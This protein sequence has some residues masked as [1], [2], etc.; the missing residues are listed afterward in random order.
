MKL[1]VVLVTFNRLECLK[2]SLDKYAKQTVLP[3]YLVVVNNASTDGTKEYLDRWYS[4]KESSF[5]KILLHSD[6]N[7]GGSGGFYLGMECAMNLDCD[8]VFLA[9]DDA[10]AE[11]NMVERLQAFE[12]EY[13][14]REELVAMCTA[15]KNKGKYDC[16]QRLSWKQGFLKING[17]ASNIAD[18]QKESFEIDALTFVGAVIRRD[19]IEKIGLPSKEYFI[20]F[21]DT[22]YSMRLRKQGKIICIPQSIMHHDT[23]DIVNITWKNYYSLRNQ[24]ITI[25]KHYPKRYYYYLLLTEYVKKCSILA[26]IL[27]KRSKA[28]RIMYKRAIK[29]AIHNE[30]GIDVVYKPG[31]NIEKIAGK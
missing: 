23:E 8:Y 7:L 15:I 10:Y 9:D 30:L 29:A 27:K 12:N 21:D 16:S 20:H 3:S 11:P 17:K 4:N 28:Q 1:A 6:K 2:I 31:I 25:C 5:E 14:C 18:Y 26:S 24:L 22:E 19:V 13:V